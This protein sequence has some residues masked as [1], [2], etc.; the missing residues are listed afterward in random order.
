MVNMFALIDDIISCVL[1]LPNWSSP[2]IC[3][4]RSF[5]SAGISVQNVTR[6]S[7]C[8]QMLPPLLRHL[9]PQKRQS[10][11]FCCSMTMAHDSS[12]EE[13]CQDS[14]VELNLYFN[15]FLLRLNCHWWIPPKTEKL[16]QDFFQPL[17]HNIDIHCANNSETRYKRIIFRLF[18][19]TAVIQATG[20]DTG[21]K[22][23]KILTSYEPYSD[24]WHHNYEKM[25]MLL[26]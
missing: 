16:L 2:I 5:M 21:C 18:N 3:S 26:L 25:K 1:T 13:S 11:F 6:L 15:G 22:S 24:L 19:S 14:A 17:S 23:L 7:W 9:I 8:L 10:N 20:C 4:Y 12:I